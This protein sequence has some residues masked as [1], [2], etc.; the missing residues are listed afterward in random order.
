MA[1][2][3]LAGSVA[4]P[5]TLP[6]PWPCLQVLYIKA[7]GAIDAHLPFPQGTPPEYEAL[8]RRCWALK[9]EDRCACHAL[10]VSTFQRQRFLR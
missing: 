1:V 5:L 6:Y 9:P 8:A 3:H 10:R 7:T 4:D 2:A